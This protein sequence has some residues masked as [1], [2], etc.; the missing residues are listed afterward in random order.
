M[1]GTASLLAAV[2]AGPLPV[3]P[4]AQVIDPPRSDATF[5][6]SVRLPIRVEGSF[7]RVEGALTPAADGHWQVEAAVDARAIRLRRHLMLCVLALAAS[8]THASEPLQVRIGYLAYI[9]ATGPLLSNVIAEPTDAGLRGAGARSSSSS[10]RKTR[11]R[12]LP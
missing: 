3:A 7:D 10:K 2:L 5:R 8:A 1:P 11:S 12:S 4:A 6:V 9:P